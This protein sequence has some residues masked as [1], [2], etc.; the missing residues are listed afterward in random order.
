MESRLAYMGSAYFD[1]WIKTLGAL[2]R[3]MIKRERRMGEALGS[4]ERRI[5]S[6][7]RMLTP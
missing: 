5:H 4:P 3:L 2:N 1:E 7:E 6:T